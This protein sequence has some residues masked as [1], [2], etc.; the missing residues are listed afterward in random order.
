MKWTVDNDWTANF[1]PLEVA[2][3]ENI[4][5]IKCNSKAEYKQQGAVTIQCN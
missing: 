3:A 5:E 1:F 4:A 2:S